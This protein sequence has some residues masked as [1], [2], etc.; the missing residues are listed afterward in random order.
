MLKWIWDEVDHRLEEGVA[1]LVGTLRE[2]I[3]ADYLRSS[4]SFGKDFH[5]VPRSSSKWL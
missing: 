2:A 3:V 1:W 4:V 5:V